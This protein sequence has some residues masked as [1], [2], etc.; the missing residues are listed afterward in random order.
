MVLGELNRTGSGPAVAIE[1]VQNN[2]GIRIHDYVAVDF[3]A[4]INFINIIGGVEVTTTYT[5]NDPAYPSMYYGYDPF[6]LPAGTHLLDG[7]TALKFARTRHGSSDFR[8]A[9]RQQ[10]VLFAIQDKMGQPGAL[11]SLIIQAPSLYVQFSENVYTGLSLDQMI[12]LAVFLKDIP[13]ENITT[14]VIDERY[15]TNYQTFDGAAVL[16][17]NRARIGNLMVE[18]FGENFAD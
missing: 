13:R 15:V 8:R 14:G 12:Q 3:Q 11:A 5:L 4:F 10:E 16:V 2:L 6:Y 7:E 9:E 18:V 17:P 1:T